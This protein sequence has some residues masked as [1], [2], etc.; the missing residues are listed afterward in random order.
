[1][2]EF[3]IGAR[4]EGTELV[5]TERVRGCPARGL[6]RAVVDR[7]DDG[8]TY[9]VTTTNRQ[10]RAL[11]EVRDDL[12]FGFEGVPPLCA[13]AP[14][15]GSDDTHHALVEEE[16]VGRPSVDGAALSTSMALTLAIELAKVVARA[17]A[18]GRILS[19]LRPE[20]VYVAGE[21]F[22]L[23]GFTPRPEH[24]IVG[25]AAHSS[26]VGPLFDTI[27]SAPEVLALSTHRTPAADVFSLS[28]CLGRWL[29]G[30]HPFAG[31]TVQSRMMAIATG[32]RRKWSGPA[33]LEPLVSA[34]LAAD[35][36]ARPTLARFIEQLEEATGAPLG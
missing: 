16:P 22:R 7:A 26:G 13:V 14:L 6:Y 10:T 21:D 28:A 18:A 8:R 31:D 15:T 9:M 5:L 32:R 33:D 1:M 24:F 29:T 27:Y 11:S 30:E 25:A 17:H 36:E 4:V 12:D 20:L 34:G 3:P 2:T 19:Y 35:P 23:A